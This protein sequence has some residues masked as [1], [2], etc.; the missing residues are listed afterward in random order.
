[1]SPNQT[2][3]GTNIDV[4]LFMND[5]LLLNITNKVL[6]LVFW[7]FIRFFNMGSKKVDVYIKLSQAI[8]I[9]SIFYAITGSFVSFKIIL[10]E[11]CIWNNEKIDKK[12]FNLDQ[13]LLV[14]FK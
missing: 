11:Y 8:V 10:N 3:S 5:C 12:C 2:T 6:I 4:P 14:A 7:I 9:S 13:K 1:M